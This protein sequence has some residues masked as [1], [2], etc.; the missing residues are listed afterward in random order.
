MRILAINPGM[1]STKSVFID[2][3][4]E[5]H[6]T[7]NHPFDELCQYPFIM[8]EFPYRREKLVEELERNGY[9]LDF[10]VVVGRGGLVKPI[11]S[12]VYELNDKVPRSAARLESGQG[13]SRLSCLHR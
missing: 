5:W 6:S 10:D 3:D 7:I 1:I 13:D 2:E 11:E 9:K 12:G 8:D 4:L